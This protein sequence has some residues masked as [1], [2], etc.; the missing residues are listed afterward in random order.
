MDKPRA[1]VFLACVDRGCIVDVKTPL[2]GILSEAL[3][4]GGH[5]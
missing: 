4:Q 1:A 3:S 5:S 2:A